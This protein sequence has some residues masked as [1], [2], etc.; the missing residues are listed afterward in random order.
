MI[1]IDSTANAA[2]YERDANL[3]AGSWS[4]HRPE[5]MLLRRFKARWAELDMLD[6]GVGGGRTSYTFSAITRSYTGIDYAPAMIELSKRRIGEDSDRRFL[7]CDARD[8]SSLYGS[9]FDFVLFSYN[10]IDSVDQSGRREILREVRRVISRDGYFAFSSHSLDA[11][12]LSLRLPRFSSGGLLRSL[13]VLGRRARLAPRVIWTNLRLD[14]DEA[15][16]QGWAAIPAEAH[17]F[18]LVVSY[19]RADFQLAQL[20]EAGFGECE[21]YDL[22][23]RRVDPGTPGRDLWLHY[24]CRPTS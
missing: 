16:E 18:K 20:E 6:I 1:E 19:V 7:V 5:Q 23:G 14:L 21:V 17:R 3:Y 13:Y 24:L 11:L 4:L 22:E 15:H 12:P 8:L 9:S 2:I 10:G